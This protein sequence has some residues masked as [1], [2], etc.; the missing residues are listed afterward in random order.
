MTWKGR[1]PG[2]WAAHCDVCGFRFPS[3]KLMKRWD[4]AMTCEKDYETRHPQTLIKIRG[5]TAVPDFTR[6]N[7][8]IFV[9]FCDIFGVT[10]YADMG[11]ADCMQA[12]KA[13]PSYQ[14][15]LDLNTNG[16]TFT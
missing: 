7:P 13:T 5:E 2:T 4:G 11:T 16:H 9:Q 3:N 14:S 8:Q 15:L 10:A 6:H 12:D 1:W